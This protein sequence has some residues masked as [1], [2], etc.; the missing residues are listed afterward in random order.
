MASGRA[1]AGGGS[2][3]RRRR[4]AA[5][6]GSTF[7][8]ALYLPTE[9]PFR[10][11]SMHRQNSLLLLDM[12]GWDADTPEVQDLLNALQGDWRSDTIIYIGN[13]ASRKSIVV[14]IVKALLATVFSSMPDASIRTNRNVTG[15]QGT[16]LQ[17]S[18]MRCIVLGAIALVLH[19]GRDN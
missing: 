17:F 11:P 19:I 18:L 2:S 13:D 6:G 5:A 14:C 3:Q 1:A 15:T 7:L 9:L 4:R 8:G 10:L 12:I 16:Q